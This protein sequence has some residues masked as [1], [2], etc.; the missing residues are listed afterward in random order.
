MLTPLK[1]A[2]KGLL[3]HQQKTSAFTWA[4]K[5]ASHLVKRAT[6]PGE[7][8]VRPSGAAQAFQIHSVQDTTKP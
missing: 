8:A 3:S 5:K 2:H 4:W 7:A 1:I 6:N